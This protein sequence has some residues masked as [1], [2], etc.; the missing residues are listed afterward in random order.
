[1]KLSY[2]MRDRKESDQEAMHGTRHKKFFTTWHCTECNQTFYF[3]VLKCVTCGTSS[4]ES[5]KNAVVDT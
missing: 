1:M 2:V 5:R 3:A 4:I